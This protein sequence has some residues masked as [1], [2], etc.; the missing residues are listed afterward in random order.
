MNTIKFYI[1]LYS[2]NDSIILQS[3]KLGVEGRRNGSAAKNNG[4]S[5]RGPGS[6]PHSGPCTRMTHKLHIFPLPCA[7]NKQFNS[8]GEKSLFFKWLPLWKC[9]SKAK[10]IAVLH[11]ASLATHCTPGQSGLQTKTSPQNK[12]KQ[13]PAFRL[14]MQLSAWCFLSTHEPSSLQ[15]FTQALKKILTQYGL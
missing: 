9:I 4:C 12:T 10:Q 3:Q 11:E 7:I 8:L 14:E 2:F 13:K 15:D 6:I 5:C 1:F